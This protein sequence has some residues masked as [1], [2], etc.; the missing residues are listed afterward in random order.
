VGGDRVRD[1]REI[2]DIVWGSA[3]NGYYLG[4]VDIASVF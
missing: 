3:D 1:V 2:R 4:R